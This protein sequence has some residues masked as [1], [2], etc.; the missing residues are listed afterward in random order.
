MHLR[1]IPTMT[2]GSTSDVKFYII[3]TSS[4]HDAGQRYAHPARPA[5]LTVLLRQHG[6]KKLYTNNMD[7]R[8][9]EFLQVRKPL[10]NDDR[11]R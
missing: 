5:H 2:G 9:L 4:P 10:V 11:G 1:V 8:K 3:D 6:I 7:F